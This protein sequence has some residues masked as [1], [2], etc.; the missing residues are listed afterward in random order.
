MHAQLA[1]LPLTIAALLI[2]VLIPALAILGLVYL[3]QRLGFEALVVN[4]E[5]AGFKYAT[6]GVAYAVLTTFLLV[7]V[8][9]RFE[10][11]E[12]AVQDEATA[13]ISLYRL[14]ETLPPADFA[15]VRRELIGY[16]EHVIAVEVP[17]MQGA[18]D[19][20]FSEGA[21][22]T[23]AIGRS[24][25]QMPDLRAVPEPVLDHLLTSYLQ[26]I[27]ARRVR[28]A[29]ADGALP[30]VLWW[31]VVVGGLICVGFTAFFASPNVVAQSIMTGLLSVI[32]MSLVF[33]TVMINHPYVG[34]IVVAFDPYA[35]ARA[36]IGADPG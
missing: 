24:I 9:E 20:G 11:A 16:L 27:D 21:R 10:Q 36:I 4:N 25:L 13:L 8:W 14:A 2:I 12:D 34:D 23:D 31:M 7:S 28:I 29:A 22:I 32:I 19:T 17:A 15:S 35:E 1:D 5:V 3:R 30:S 33:S 26:I 6:M 18:R